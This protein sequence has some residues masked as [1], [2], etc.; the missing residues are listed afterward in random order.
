MKDVL[1]YG[2]IMFGVGLILGVAN[3]VLAEGIISGVKEMND[4]T[5]A[6]KEQPTEV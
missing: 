6:E 2:G 5:E 1:K 4:K 3:Y